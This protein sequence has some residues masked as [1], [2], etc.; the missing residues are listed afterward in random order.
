M[1]NESPLFSSSLMRRVA[2]IAGI[3]LIVV[4]V[5]NVGIKWY[6][7][8]ILKAGHTTAT[9][10]VEI[11]IGNDRLKL[12]KNTLRMPAD[13]QGGEQERIDLYLTW[14]DLKGYEDAN[15]AAFDDP[16]H[17]T[18]LIFIQL[19]QSTMSQDMSGRFGPIYARLT[20]GEPVPLKHGLLL[21]RLRPDS[22]YG[23]EVVLTGQREGES[24]YVVRCLLPQKPEET[25]GSDCQRDI[26]VGQ[27][28]T[29]F[30]RFSASLLPQWQKLD[31]DVK[32]YVEQRLLKDGNT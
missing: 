20:Q 30:Y 6:G 5:L 8:R 12:A 7:E 4:I 16:A 21:H 17:V 26:H 15:R 28:L 13:R 1:Q 25:T 27:D 19:S 2:V 9:D 22:G 24:D 29:L 14:P 32:A 18:G 10:T 11:T 23:K 31:A 3:L